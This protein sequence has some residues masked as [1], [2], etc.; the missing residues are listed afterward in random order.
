MKDERKTKAQLINELAELR[1]QFNSFL[2]SLPDALI[3]VDILTSRLTRMNRAAY[4]LLAIQ[5]K[6]SPRSRFL[7]CSP[8]MN[9]NEPSKLLLATS[10]RIRS[11]ELNM[12]ALPNR[13][14][15][16]S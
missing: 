10:Q 13:N 2:Y 15:T 1:Q 4:N 11:L 3:E 9:T 5:N 12:S 7:N 14:S 8:K 6:I 16:N